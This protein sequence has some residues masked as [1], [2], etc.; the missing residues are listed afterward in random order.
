VAIARF[1]H[2][3]LAGEPE[4]FPL[5]AWLAAFGAFSLVAVYGTVCLGGL[6][7]LWDVESRVPL[8]VAVVLGTAGSVGAL[9]G[10]VYKVPSPTSWVPWVVLAWT[11]AGVAL[12][13]ALRA[14][15]RLHPA[16]GLTSEGAADARVRGARADARADAPEL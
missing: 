10:A 3:V 12:T 1:G 4:Y 14:S 8:V 11:A 9:F 6:R 2:G 7:G 5:F 15:G 16:V 13:L